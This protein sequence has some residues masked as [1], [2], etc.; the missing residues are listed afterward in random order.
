MGKQSQ[1]SF[2]IGKDTFFSLPAYLLPQYSTGA[3]GLGW[4]VHARCKETS[5]NPQPQQYLWWQEREP[6]RLAGDTRPLR[7]ERSSPAPG[8]EVSEKDRV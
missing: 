8:K 1:E 2:V 7:P 5:G 6:C 3:A 4:A